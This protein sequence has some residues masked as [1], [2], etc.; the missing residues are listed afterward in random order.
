MF[1]HDSVTRGNAVAVHPS[2]QLSYE[3]DRF[4]VGMRLVYEL[5]LNRNVVRCSVRRVLLRSTSR[6]VCDYLMIDLLIGSFEQA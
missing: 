6:T 1:R 3:G 2:N 5:Y 4:A